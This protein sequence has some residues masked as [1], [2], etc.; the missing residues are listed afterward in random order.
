M[1]F[2]AIKY[3]QA[4][5]L[6][7]TS[8]L[9]RLESDVLHI[10]K[11]ENNIIHIQIFHRGWKEI[12]WALHFVFSFKNLC[13]NKFFKNK[14]KILIFKKKAVIESLFSSVPCSR[15]AELGALKK[16]IIDFPS[17]GGL[18]SKIKLGKTQR[19]FSCYLL[20]Q[21][22]FSLLRYQQQSVVFNSNK[23]QDRIYAGRAGSKLNLS[24]P[25]FCNP[26]CIF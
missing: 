23:S 10:K 12:Y 16:K 17:L 1:F 26:V 8:E 25:R 11:E 20:P 14:S 18:R 15:A 21:H 22:T 19:H 3:F 24:K 4:F 2:Y 7:F 5:K 13:N 9:Q 6:I